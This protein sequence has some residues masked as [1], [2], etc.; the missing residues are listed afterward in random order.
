MREASTT[1]PAAVASSKVMG[2][3][4]WHVDGIATTCVLLRAS[5]RASLSRNP[6]KVMLD[7]VPARR[8]RS[9][10]RGPRPATVRLTVDPRIASISTSTP[11]SF[12]RRP[13]YN[14]RRGPLRGGSSHSHRGHG[15]RMT[16]SGVV[17]D[18][19]RRMLSARKW[20]GATRASHRS[21]PHLSF[22]RIENST[23]ATRLAPI[24]PS[25]HRCR[26]HDPTPPRVHCHSQRAPSPCTRTYVGQI[27]HAS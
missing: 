11:F 26:T 2:A 12:A 10:S 19:S 1:R 7:E 27:G 22:S 16:C 14:T 20:L 5:L 9:S 25:T 8:R 18:N 24:R 13:K 17:V 3:F 15:C 6:T 4:S 21:S 23:A